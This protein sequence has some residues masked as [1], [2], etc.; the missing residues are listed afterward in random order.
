MKSLY[1]LTFHCHHENKKEISFYDEKANPIKLIIEEFALFLKSS[2]AKSILKN[3][4][5]YLFLIPTS[6]ASKTLPKDEVKDILR[7]HLRRPEK[8]YVYYI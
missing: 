8:K 3:N 2:E 1:Y 6:I 5:F 4:F 7:V